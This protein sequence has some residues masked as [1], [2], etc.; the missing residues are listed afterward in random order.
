M[1]GVQTCAL[2]IFIYNP[3]S[4]AIHFGDP[5][6][7]GPLLSGVFGNVLAPGPDTYRITVMIEADIFSGPSGDVYIL[8]N[9]SG[10]M[11]LKRK[12][13]SSLEFREIKNYDHSPI[14]VEPLS[15]RP[16][17]EVIG[18]VTGSSGARPADRDYTDKR[19]VKD[20]I[21]HGGK[22]IDSQEQVGGFPKALTI[23]RAFNAPVN[24]NGDD[25]GDGYTNL[26]EQLFKIADGVES[27][28]L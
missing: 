12:L 16:S 17:G 27:S 4:A 11:T 24:P 8:D 10:G 23:T 1:T 18:W 6:K 15:I 25:D 28:P 9:T 14:R 20:F 22:I 13:A 2:P 19:M 7:S 26:E 3:G 5:L 21:N